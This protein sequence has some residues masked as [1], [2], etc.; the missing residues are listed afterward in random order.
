MNY[1]SESAQS[2][3]SSPLKLSIQY[4]LPTKRSVTRN[5]RKN[6]STFK[7]IGRAN[8]VLQR[9][10]RKIHQEIKCGRM[11]GAKPFNLHFSSAAV[12]KFMGKSFPFTT[13]W[14]EL[15]LKSGCKQNLFYIVLTICLS[16]SSDTTLQ[17][18]FHNFA[19]IK[20]SIN[21]VGIVQRRLSLVSHIIKL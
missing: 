6:E 20:Y 4:T 14:F 11:H 18:T 16:H 7:S 8:F 19:L 13:Q 21:C 15:R 10:A 5:E 3:A 17:K 9:Q 2:F 12:Q 1:S